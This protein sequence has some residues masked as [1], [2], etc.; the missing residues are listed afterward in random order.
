[1]ETISRVYTHAQ[2]SKRKG[3]IHA[4]ENLVHSMFVA[5]VWFLAVACLV[6]KM[7]AAPCRYC[8]LFNRFNTHTSHNPQKWSILSIERF[9]YSKIIQSN[10]ISFHS[11]SIWANCRWKKSNDQPTN[12]CKTILL[13][14]IHNL[15]IHANQ[16][17]W[18]ICGNTWQMKA[19][20][21]EFIFIIIIETVDWS[22]NRMCRAALL[23]AICNW[24]V[25]D[26]KFLSAIRNKCRSI[27]AAT[28]WSG[29]SFE[30]HKFT[31]ERLK[32]SRC[33]CVCHRNNF[34]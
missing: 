14:S 7:K 15:H 25:T 22:T 10:P 34:F 19:I 8:A 30:N 32:I 31:Y 29:E 20:R 23:I 13:Q 5:N 11:L 3:C 12:H 17:I 4:R 1:M 24:L 33:M 26:F 6:T 21:N 18:R 16:M 9:F 28:V 27:N 2:V